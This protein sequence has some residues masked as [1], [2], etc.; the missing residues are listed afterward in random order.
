[1]IF[2]IMGLPGSGKTYLASNIAYTLKAFHTNTDS[3][4]KKLNLKGVYTEEAKEK[5]YKAMFKEVEEKLSKYPFCIIDATFSK[6]A[7]R[8]KA[9]DYF[10][11]LDVEIRFVE[12]I[13][14]EEIIQQRVNKA[15]KDSE[16]DYKVYQKIK[17]AFDPMPEPHLRLDTGK[18]SV[19]TLTD[20]FL[21][22]FNLTM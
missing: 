11:S 8:Q 2:A 4:R 9:I 7:Y 22:H 21:E 12:T 14:D 19:E 20:R 1:M 3:V 16:A 18:Y 17:A 10:A 6:Q 15:R 5:V 13:A